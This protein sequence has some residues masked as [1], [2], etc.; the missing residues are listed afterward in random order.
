MADFHPQDCH[1][2]AFAT[3]KGAIRLADLRISALADESCKSFEEVR[4]RLS[5][6][7]HLQTPLTRVCERACGLVPPITSRAVSRHARRTDGDTV[8]VSSGTLLAL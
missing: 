3:S 5:S 2:F 8:S 4:A 1:T 6:P 7:C